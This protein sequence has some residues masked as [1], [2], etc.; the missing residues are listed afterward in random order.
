MFIQVMY[1]VLSSFLPFGRPRMF[2]Q[3]MYQVLSSFLP[4]GRPRMFIQVLYQ[5]LSF[6]LPFGRPRDLFCLGGSCWGASGCLCFCCWGSSG[7]RAKV[8]AGTFSSRSYSKCWSP[9]PATNLSSMP[10]G[11]FC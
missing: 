10:S 3:V 1:Q 6:F 5:L 2:I 8:G 7:A 9:K 11:M 4:F